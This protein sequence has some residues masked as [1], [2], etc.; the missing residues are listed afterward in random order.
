LLTLDV[1]AWS[2]IPSDQNRNVH[3]S[4]SLVSDQLR[5]QDDLSVRF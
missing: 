4:N 1:N 3:P 2:R 5:K